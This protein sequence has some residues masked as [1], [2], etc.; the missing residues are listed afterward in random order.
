MPRILF[1]TSAALS[2]STSSRKNTFYVCCFHLNCDAL[3]RLA[4]TGVYVLIAR[5]A[6]L[7]SFMEH[8]CQ[9]YRE[10]SWRHDASLFHSVFNRGLQ[11]VSERSLFKWHYSSNLANIQRCR[12]ITCYTT[13]P[14][15][16][17]IIIII[18]DT[19]I[20]QK[21]NFKHEKL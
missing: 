18:F 11:C 17:N 20:T 12:P 19:V 14:L 5:R 21:R 15:D 3:N 7:E 13:V 6:V 9:V 8:S 2:E 10:E 1:A 4:L 16:N